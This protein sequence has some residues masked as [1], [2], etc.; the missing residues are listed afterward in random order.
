[1]R[2]FVGLA[3]VMA[4]LA[5][6][7]VAAAGPLVNNAELDFTGSVRITFEGVIDWI[8]PIG[9]GNGTAVI[10]PTSTLS[11]APLAGTIVTELDLNIASQPAGPVGTFTPLSG[12]ETLAAQ[13][14]TNFTLLAI[15]Q[16]TVG[17]AAGPTS[18][19]NFV[20]IGGS[21]TVII[22][23]RGTAVDPVLN[24]GQTFTWVGTWSADFPGQTP[25][26]ILA[27]LSGPGT[28]IDAPYS[29]AKIA[30]AQT[31][32]V[33]EPATLLTL[34]TGGVLAAIRRRRQRATA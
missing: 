17:C 25:T 30:T 7:R 27:Q 29:A 22:T 16:C 5:M 32:P 33:P 15:D 14:T 18:P 3:V 24:P 10:Q 26:Q 34:G 23:M 28:F 4:A 11:F 6:P 2:K 31:T 9:G 8:P 13:P 20:T 19:F 21:T 12:F 1:M